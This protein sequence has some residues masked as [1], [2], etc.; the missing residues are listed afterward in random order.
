MLALASYNSGQGRVARAIR[1]NAK[2]GKPTDFWNL[3]LPAETRGYVP[4][5]LGLTCLFLNAEQLRV[6]HAP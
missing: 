4:K 3:K 6:R 5:L 1:S 2:A